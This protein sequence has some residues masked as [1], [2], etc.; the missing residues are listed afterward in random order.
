MLKLFTV[1]HRSC[2]VPKG[3]LSKWQKLWLREVAALATQWKL[4]IPQICGNIN[5]LHVETVSFSELHISD[6]SVGNNEI[7][8]KSQLL[9]CLEYYILS[10]KLH[11]NLRDY[12]KTKCIGQVLHPQPTVSC[13]KTT[14]RPCTNQPTSLRDLKTGAFQNAE[15]FSFIPYPTLPLKAPISIQ[16]TWPALP[17]RGMEKSQPLSSPRF[18]RR[19][20]IQR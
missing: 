14:M 9:D 7:P 15:V 20:F 6:E 4:E 5:G 1:H 19:K 3:L 17:T 10:P 8:T 18:Q 11:G 12:T 2:P 16:G 13:F